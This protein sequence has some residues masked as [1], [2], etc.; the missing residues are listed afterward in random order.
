MTQ[1]KKRALWS[2]A[3]FVPVSL[4]FLAVFFW[5]G[6]PAAYAQDR[7]RKLLAAGLFLAGYGSYFLML[8]RTRTGGGSRGIVTDER[9]ATISRHANNAA[10]IAVLVFVYTLCISLW[11]VFEEAGALAT[12][13]MQFVAYATVFFGLL[14][15]ASATL[16]L[17]SRGITNGQG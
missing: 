14:A 6:G 5:G 7:V 8:F 9:E 10:L 2:L 3:I 16:I 11:I 17:D 13:W 1:I 15:Q 12:G 4:A